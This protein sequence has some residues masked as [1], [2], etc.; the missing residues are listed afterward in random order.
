MFTILSYD[1][2]K[3]GD[4]GSG[5]MFGAIGVGALVGPIVIRYFFGSSDGRLLNTIGFTI[6]A[7]GLFYFF[8]E[9]FYRGEPSRMAWAMFFTTFLNRA[10][11][12]L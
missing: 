11:K 3:A 5:I 7:W 10:V 2:F 6:M 9:I 1:I 8:K 4:Y 12:F